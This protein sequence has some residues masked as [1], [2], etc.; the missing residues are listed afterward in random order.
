MDNL[1]ELARR[2]IEDKK[3]GRKAV[4]SRV[5]DIVNGEPTGFVFDCCE[6]IP[7]IEITDDGQILYGGYTA[8]ELESICA[9]NKSLHLPRDSQRGWLT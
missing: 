1:H 6:T 4:I 5:G 3:A 9:A 8:D 7:A 2:I